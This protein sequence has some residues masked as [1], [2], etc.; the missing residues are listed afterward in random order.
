MPPL[1]HDRRA[2]GWEEVA[3]VDHGALV[4]R[5][6]S[7]LARINE[8][9][10]ALDPHKGIRGPGAEAA[11][12]VRPPA[13]PARPV[14]PGSGPAERPSAFLLAVL[15]AAAPFSLFAIVAVAIARGL[16][17]WELGLFAIPFLL[18]ALTVTL[19]GYR[20]YR[21]PHVARRTQRR[22][23]TPHARG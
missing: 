20:L 5:L 18:A 4:V 6:R 2:F 1:T 14:L 22:D 19:E 9:G 16:H 13:S 21:E 15:A 7:E 11:R 8:A 17:G 12:L 3:E 10:L 23:L